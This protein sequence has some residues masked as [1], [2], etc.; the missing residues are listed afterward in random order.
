MTAATPAEASFCAASAAVRG[1]PPSSSTTSSIFRPLTPPLLLASSTNRAT[2]FFMSWPSEAH[3]PVSGH[4]SPTLTSAATAAAGRSRARAR[5][6]SQKCSPF[7]EYPHPGMRI[8][9]VNK[10][11]TPKCKKAKAPGQASAKGDQSGAGRMVCRRQKNASFPVRR[12][13]KPRQP[14]GI[15]IG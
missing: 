9:S 1:S 7:M 2:I 11:H 13:R 12:S 4:M 3:L 15:G 10:Q 5:A 6:P 14:K 8:V